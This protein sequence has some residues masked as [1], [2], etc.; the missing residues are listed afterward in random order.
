MHLFAAGR[1]S[2]LP[3]SSSHFNPIQRGFIDMILISVQ[4]HDL[5]V[6]VFL[7]QGVEREVHIS[8][9]SFQHACAVGAVLLFLFF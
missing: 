2:S 1:S 4:P 3:L 8:H 6:S 9:W 5:I 7:S